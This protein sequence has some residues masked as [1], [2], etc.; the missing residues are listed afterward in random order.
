MIYNNKLRKAKSAYNIRLEEF[1]FSKQLKLCYISESA[2]NR[3]ESAREIFESDLNNKGKRFIPD[4][5][6][7]SEALDFSLKPFER[8][9]SDPAGYSIKQLIE[10]GY[11]LSI[12]SIK[13]D[14]SLIELCNGVTLITGTSN[15]G[16]STLIREIQAQ[17]NCEVIPFGEPIVTSLNST[18]ELGEAIGEFLVDDRDILIVDSITEFLFASGTEAATSGGLSTSLLVDINRISNICARQGKSLILVLNL[19]SQKDSVVVDALL[20]RVHGMIHIPTRGRLE[21]CSRITPEHRSMKLVDWNINSRETLNI[22]SIVKDI[23]IIDVI[24]DRDVTFD[25][26]NH[27]LSLDKK[28]RWNVV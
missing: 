15:V 12:G 13:I 23:K 14:D 9:S 28:G 7:F 18:N 10:N 16:K 2:M 26:N 21:V 6:T 27:Q 17:L 5:S 24:A 25:A 22:A 4:S 11:N 3:E 1:F 8:D 20:G 19:L